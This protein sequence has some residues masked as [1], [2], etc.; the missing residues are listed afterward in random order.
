MA[1]SQTVIRM[2][3]WTCRRC[4]G[5][6]PKPIMKMAQPVC[7]WCGEVIGQPLGV[8]SSEAQRDRVKR[9][10][11]LTSDNGGLGEE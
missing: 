8:G 1:L 4:E 11:G 10:Y 6:F 3:K 2:A 9:H 5:G 7:P